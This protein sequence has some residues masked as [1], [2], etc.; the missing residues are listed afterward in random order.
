MRFGSFCLL[1]FCAIVLTGTIVSA[2]RPVNEDD[3][4]DNTV[5]ASSATG[6]DYQHGRQAFAERPE[7]EEENEEVDDVLRSMPDESRQQAIS[8]FKSNLY[9]H[10]LTMIHIRKKSIIL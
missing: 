9:V 4:E 2:T 3:L 10:L 8:Y 6:H 1:F 7:E 5:Q